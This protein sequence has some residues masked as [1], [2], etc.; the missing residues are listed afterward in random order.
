MQR[1]LVLALILV[2]AVVVGAVWMLTRGDSPPPP[3][4]TSG[5]IPAASTVD[6]Q[7]SGVAATARNANAAAMQREGVA[8]KVSPLLEDPEIRAGLTGFKGRVVHRANAPVADCG[9]RL[10][11]GALDSVLPDGFDLLAEV[12]DYEPQY[13]AGET[14]TGTDGTF[15]I[16][17]VWPR[18]FY[19]L[20]AGIGTDAPTY[21]IV[22]RL[23]SP[24][25][26]VDLGDVVLSE[27]GVITG[28]VLDENGDPLPGALVRAADL[29]GTIAAFFPLERFD[30]EGAV[31]IRERQAP[32]RVVEMPKWVKRAFENLPIPSGLTDGSGRFRLVGVRPGSNLLATTMRGYLSDMKPS[33]QVRAGQ[34][35]DAGSIRMKRGE[36][37]TG[38]VLDTAG[39]P[40]AG[41]E[42]LAG[43]TLAMVP[44]DLA[45]KLGATD[46]DGRFEGQGYAPG[47]VTVAARRGAGHPWILAEPQP[48]FGDVVVRLPATFAINATVTLA[49]GTPVAAPRLR[50][51]CGTAGDGAAEMYLMGFS[52]PVDLADRLKPVAEGK[53][54]IE[55]LNPGP[56]TLVADA[57]GCAV[58]FTSFE[59]TTTDVGAALQL[60]PPNVFT[61]RVLNHEDKPIRNATIYA[62]ARGV[63]VVE[64]P[65]R[66]GRTDTDGML[67]IDRLQAESLRVSA[68][69][70][71]WGVVNG[72]VKV[73]EELVLRMLQPGSLR[74]TL[75]EN[76]K[77][78][79]PGKFTVALMRRRGNEAR[80][81]LEQ[82]PGLLTPGIDGSFAV[83]ALQPGSYQVSAIKSLDALQSPG[84]VFMLAQD[85]YLMRDVPD[86][87]FEITAGQT[88]EV[89]L[90]AG[91]KPIEGP[92]GTVSGSVMIDG[93]LAAGAF[94]TAYANQRRFS[95]KVD[96][97]G[98]FELGTVPAG[99]LWLSVNNSSESGVFMG[100]GGNLYSANVKLAEGEAKEVSID[101]ATSAMSGVCYLPDGQPAAGVHVQA[102]G[103]LKGSDRSGGLWL[104]TSTD[105]EGAFA[106]KQVAAGTWTLSVSAR[107][108]ESARGRL[109][110][111]EVNGGVPVE[112]LRIELQK[113]LVVKGRVDMQVFA[114]KKPRW[115]WVGFY[116]VTDKTP[117]DAQGDYVD[118]VG[119]DET[120]GEFS[121]DELTPGTYRVRL[122]AGFEGSPGAEYTCEEITV[123]ATGL[124]GVV[125]H[126]TVR[127]R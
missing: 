95:A 28:T 2:L 17:G 4:P 116:R 121:S 1:S 32:V 52:P 18:A 113:S 48:V 72:E 36:E 127:A 112:G 104:N 81:P 38:R 87:R 43:S 110:G 66:C 33:I 75:T 123:P 47:N 106:F 23:P 16:T 74:G 69:H 13:I 12:P 120:S 101:I 80:G 98:R 76:G 29:P 86:Q 71:R 114:Q 8:A 100:P 15:L 124:E 108:K 19:L 54:R 44:F 27:A 59:I 73:N 53:W 6:S 84:G 62:E 78:P 77:P 3:P 93:R 34:E 115:C 55:N 122:H 5:A 94:V 9:V 49:D 35:K 45:Q 107:G 63:R 39:K 11:R 65:T 46:A 58:A 126:P 83:A 125:L 51:L 24:G 117:A 25:E 103:T 105:A 99:D 89:Q 14:K 119:L 41:A 97:R 91:E 50:L 70:P 85:M 111:I 102:Q 26:I 96:G 64:M 109:E 20:H 79:S 61:V 10:F 92:T 22:T 68:D 56:Y 67:V 7:A 30:P 57:P 88:T 82:V 42:V 40:I 31:L 90:E 60:T 21:Q 37:L 118:G